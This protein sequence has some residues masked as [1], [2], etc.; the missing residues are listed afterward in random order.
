MTRKLVRIITSFATFLELAPQDVLEPAD[1]VKQE[2]DI[3]SVV[4][5]LTGEE[6]ASS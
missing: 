1:A 3:A 6:R 5:Q 2:E 4:Q